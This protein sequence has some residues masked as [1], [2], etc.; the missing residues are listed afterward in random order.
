MKI[1][2]G[3]LGATGLVG[4]QYLLRLANHPQF[5][6]VYLAASERSEGKTYAEAVQGRWRQSEPIP[7]KLAKQIVEPLT[8]TPQAQ[9]LFSALDN[10][11]ARVFEPQFAAL[12]Y[13]VFSNASWGR[14]ESDVPVVIPEVNAHHL[15]WLVRQKQERGWKGFLVAKPCCTVQSFVIPL[16]ALHKKWPIKK[17]FVTSLQAL[18]GAG[19]SGEAHADNVIPHISGEEEKL[20]NEPRKILGADL[21]ISAHCNRVPV[22]DGHL[23]CV[24]F[25]FQED[26]PTK[27]EILDAWK[28]FPALDLPSA[29]RQTIHYFSQEDRPQPLQDR[30]LENGMAAS[31]GR[32]RP[33]PLLHWRFVS[34]THNT[35]RGAAGGGILCAELFVQQGLL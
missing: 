13:A 32:L 10:G 33:C 11:S 2:V 30:D 4:Q 22:S 28:S 34:L 12:G 15:D 27:E 16:A 25:A 35:A 29:P 23:T 6:V 7:E 5:E 8:A 18:S 21:V 1:P 24:S 26:Q 3:I 20:E 19:L 14:T 9:L 17:V 31:V